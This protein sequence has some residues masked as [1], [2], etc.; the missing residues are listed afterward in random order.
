M[1]EP[2]TFS[3]VIPNYNSGHQLERAIRSLLTQDYP[4]LQLIIADAESTDES[5]Q[6]IEKYR[7]HF[8][9][10]IIKKDKGQ[11]DGLN[12]G[13]KHARGDVFGWL[14]ADD[15]LQPGALHHVNELF[16]SHPD[17][18]VITGGCQR[19][20]AD[21]TTRLIPANEDPWSKVHIQNSIE[22]PS[23]FWRGG[24]HRKVG[25]LDDS[26]RLAFDWDFWN[27]FRG[28]G[29]GI[30]ATQ[31]PLSNYY[32]TET[33]KS[34]NSGRGHVTESFR[35]VRQYGP[36]GGALAHIFRFL[37]FNFD[38]HGCYD[39]PPTCGL[40]RSHV[41]IWTLALLRALIGKRYLYLYNWHFASCQE[42]GLKWW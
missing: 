16:Q 7:P 10:V 6:T 31:R 23:T 1:P 38:L 20:F 32:F 13:F 3:I 30:L 5:R 35:I 40:L 22:Q 11:A 15:E 37:Y 19:I 8:D 9:T 34:G 4:N 29:S 17:V 42:R 2:L 39:N 14:C 18:D 28:A 26:Y 25:E 27:R 33:N 36:M 24:L 12:Q 21:G 41:F